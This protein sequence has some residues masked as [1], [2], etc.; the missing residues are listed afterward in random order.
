MLFTHTVGK[1]LSV[2]ETWTQTIIPVCVFFI[3][4]SFQSPILWFSCQKNIL[5]LS[6]TT[7]P[8]CHSSVYQQSVSCSYINTKC[9][10]QQRG[11]QREF[12]TVCKVTDCQHPHFDQHLVQKPYNQTNTFSCEDMKLRFLVSTTTTH[13]H[14]YSLVLKKRRLKEVDGG[15]KKGGTFFHFSVR[16]WRVL[17]CWKL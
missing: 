10:C 9:S 3:C 7:M 15:G 13:T 12:G 16:Y 1:W 11:K 8:P 2:K 6:L 4:T 17:F 14:R 5:S